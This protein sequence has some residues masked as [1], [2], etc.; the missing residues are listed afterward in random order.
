MTAVSQLVPN[1][2]GGI[3]E[4]PDELKKPGQVRDCVN[5]MPDVT[6]G[7]I[8][9]PGIEWIDKLDNISGNG[10]WIE[11]YRKNQTG[12]TADYLGYIET[13]GQ[14]YFWSLDG[15]PEDVYYSTNS[16]KPGKFYTSSEVEDLNLVNFDVFRSGYTSINKPNDFSPFYLNKQNQK[17]LKTVSIRDN[18]FITNPAIIAEMQTSEPTTTQQNKYYAFV[19]AKVF[20]VSRTYTLK[21]DPINDDGSITRVV[22]DVEDIKTSGLNSRDS[23]NGEVPLTD[24]NN[25]NNSY[26]G[27]TFEGITIDGAGNRTLGS[28]TLDTSNDQDGNSTSLQ[29]KSDRT[30]LQIEFKLRGQL[31][32]KGTDRMQYDLVDFKIVDGGTDFKRGEIVYFKARAKAGQ[33]VNNKDTFTLWIQ[34]PDTEDS[35]DKEFIPDGR[36]TAT[37]IDSDSDWGSIEQVLVGLKESIDSQ[38]DDGIFLDNSG[39]SKVQIYGNGLYLESQTPFLIDSPDLDL[40][41]VINSE[42]T[43]QDIVPIA[44]VNNISNLPIECKPKFKVKVLNSFN[45]EDDAYFKFRNTIPTGTNNEG[46]ADEDVII[47]NSG[48]G[49]WEEIAKPFEPVEF[50]NRTMPHMITSTGAGFVVSRAN[51]KKRT[52]GTEDFNPSF[53]EDTAKITSLNFF[54][55]R[56]VFTTTVGTIVTST[57][58]NILDFF[59]QT[60]LSSSL[61][62]PVDVISNSS[63]LDPLYDSIVTNNSLVVFGGSSQYQFFTTSDLLTPSTVNVTQIASYE[64]E[65]NSRPQ[66]LS[67]NI[68]FVTSKKATRMYEMTNVFDRG[69]ADVNE[70]SKIIQA[71]FAKGYTYTSSSRIYNILAY[72]HPQPRKQERFDSDIALG[73][74][75]WIYAYLKDSSQSDQ[76]TAWVKFEFPHPVKHHFFYEN[77]MYIITGNTKANKDATDCYLTSLDLESFDTSYSDPNAIPEFID[78]WQKIPSIEN[79]P[80]EETG[81][82]DLVPSSFSRYPDKE[83]IMVR[84]IKYKST[85]ELPKFYVN[86]SEGSSYQS[87]TTASLTMHRYKINH[88]AVG[89]YRVELTR[90]GKDAY[91]MLYEQPYEDAVTAAPGYP[92]YPIALEQ[93]QTIPIY[94][95]NV[96]INMSITS[97]FNLPCIIYSLRWEGDYTN[98]YYKRV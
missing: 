38:D 21:I 35:I 5:F 78:Y 17:A 32:T 57:S 46:D 63:K 10:T 50:K 80:W 8:K 40:C 55:N 79:L 86:K 82:E 7:L 30:K 58:E 70:R 74:I 42:K 19:E 68:S 9:R 14:V 93:E 53:I 28:N 3:N 95:R 98:R 45:K 13:D 67:T 92:D 51:W 94:D 48:Q 22:D 41:N 20:D 71:K 31:I 56:L 72:S 73:K 54:K 91:T 90:Y 44:Y 62:D 61:I 83:P 47:E 27:V 16:L 65:P 77:K 29:V 85:V 66:M 97:D 37:A 15:T 24:F 64:F 59:P 25:P 81:D 18:I 84:G 26:S 4:Q 34:I 12:R 33:G 43:S 69:Q 23:D 88:G 52:A 49:Y 36:I 2:F 6:Y 60:A 89:A 75:M 11:F 76:Q 96:N 39:E 87:D 1:F